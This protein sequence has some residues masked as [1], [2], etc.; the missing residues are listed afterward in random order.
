MSSREVRIITVSREYGS[1]GASIAKELAA[2]LGFSLLD[3]SLVQRLAETARVA[4]EV[5]RRL[6]ERVDPWLYRL[7]KSLWRGALESV[8]VQGDVVDA[9]ELAAAARTLIEE[10]DRLGRCVVVGRGAQCILRGR[11]GVFHLFVYAP[12]EERIARMHDRLAPGE[13]VEAVMDSVDRE[14]SA[15]I[16]RHFGTDWTDRRLYH[17]MVNSTIGQPAVVAT[18]L[19]ALGEN[20][21]GPIEGP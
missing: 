2:R 15:Y 12:R 20:R 19:A 21:P 7:S 13:D 3:R 10:V 6:D 8:A 5:A 16:E 14:R 18:V 1:G 9:D 4:P 11:E 17:L